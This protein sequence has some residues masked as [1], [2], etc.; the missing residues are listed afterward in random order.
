MAV[1]IIRAGEDG[2][3][4]IGWSSHVARRAQEIRSPWCPDAELT[5]I[6]LVEGPRWLEGWFSLK[7][8]QCVSFNAGMV[9]V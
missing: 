4:K 8:V 6:R 9:H 7:R 5:V 1:Y 3:V 2:P